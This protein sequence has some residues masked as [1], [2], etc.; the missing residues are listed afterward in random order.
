MDSFWRSIL[1]DGLFKTL[2]LL[3][4]PL[5]WWYITARKNISFFSWIGLTKVKK[6]N[7]KWFSFSIVA[8]IIFIF[9]MPMFYN[10]LHPEFFESEGVGDVNF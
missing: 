9:L 4:I 8:T 5:L 6:N 10:L 3:I 2:L 7:P 1:V